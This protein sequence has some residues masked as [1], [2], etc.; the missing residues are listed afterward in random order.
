MIQ[1]NRLADRHL[2]PRALKN[3][4]QSTYITIFTHYT[5]Y[6]TKQ[7]MIKRLHLSAH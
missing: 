7:V 5:P 4:V 6:V 1:N 2:E 3:V